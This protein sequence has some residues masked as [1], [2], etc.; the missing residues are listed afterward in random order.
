MDIMIQRQLDNMA[1]GN[2]A[3]LET[4]LRMVKRAGMDIRI[5]F[6]PWQSFGNRPWTSVHPRLAGLTKNIVWPGA[7]KLGSRYW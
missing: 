1:T 5:V 3:Y 6:A 7:V 4:F 2:S